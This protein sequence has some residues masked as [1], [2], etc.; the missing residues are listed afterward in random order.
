M[1]IDFKF[2]VDRL[3]L[4]NGFDRFVKPWIFQV[5]ALIDFQFVFIQVH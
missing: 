4:I 2:F 5:L 1:W 3:H